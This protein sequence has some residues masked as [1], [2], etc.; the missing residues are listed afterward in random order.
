LSVLIDT[1][2]L[3]WLGFR[4]GARMSIR[5]EHDGPGVVPGRYA[6]EAIQLHDGPTPQSVADE[7]QRAHADALAGRICAAAAEAAHSTYTLLELLG[8]F[9]ATNAIR[10]WTGFK[11]L[12]HWL[13]WSCS[14]TPGVAR[15]HVRV[16]KALR[17]MPTIAG[18]FR[19]ARL[20]YSKVREVTRVVDVVDEQR[21]AQLALTATASQLARMISGFRSTDGLRIKQQTKRRVL[22]H[23]RDDGMIEFRARLPKEEAARLLAAMNAAKDQFGPP[24]P[25]PDPC[26]AAEQELSPGVGVYSNADA[27]LD[28][29][30]GFLNTAPEDRSGEDRTLVVVHVSAENLA[31][32]VPDVPAGTSQ[33]SEAVGH[34]AG[35]GSVEAGTAQRLACDNPLLG[36]IVDKHGKVLALGRTRRLVSKA[37]RRALLIRDKMCC[38]T[39]CHQTRHLKAH[40]VVPWSLGGSTDLDNLI[41]LCQWHHTA[42]H[43]GG[44]T[45]TRDPD[46]WVFS[47]P[48]GQTCQPWVSDENLARHL[49]FALR[50]RQ[51]AHLDQLAAVDSFQHPDARIIRPRWAGEVFDLHACVQALFTIKLPQ[52]PHQDQQAA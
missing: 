20:S 45:I 36:V 51:Q 40:H 23:E 8:E 10:Y 4:E 34:I 14:M 30:R 42:V 13:S 19:E 7:E 12:A 16:A 21:L 52:Q 29:A 11:S 43:E 18:L 47:K 2:F 6:G 48:D 27:L 22:W 24:P 33:P 31:R 15:E 5:N 44:V 49:G 39:G 35:V 38:Y 41:L 32:T 3:V 17:R 37:Q 9:D 50:K 46:G 1:F 28:V 25:K 26:G